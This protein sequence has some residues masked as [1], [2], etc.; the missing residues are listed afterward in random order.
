MKY[1]IDSKIQAPA[2]QQLYKQIRDDIINGIYLYKTKLP[3]K[4]T[5]AEELNISTVTVEHAYELLCDEGYI[6]AKERSGYF[7]IFRTDDGFINTQTESS[8][9]LAEHHSSVSTS[10]PI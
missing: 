9:L 4:R 1:L 8:L 6:E 5:V 2:Y 3:S 10:F 7:V